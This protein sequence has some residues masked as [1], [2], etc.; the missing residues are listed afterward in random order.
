M[1]AGQAGLAD[2]GVARGADHACGGADAA[3]FAEMAAD[4]HDPVV[5]ELGTEADGAFVGTLCFADDEKSRRVLH[6]VL[7]S[8]STRVTAES[9]DRKEAQSSRLGA[10]RIGVYQPWMPSMDEGWTRLVLEKF[11][12]P[13]VTLHNAEICAGYLRGRVDTLLLPS[14]DAKEIRSGSSANETE[15]ADV[16]GSGRKGRRRCGPSSGRAG[17]WSAWKTRASTRTR[18]WACPSRMS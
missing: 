10:R 1:I 4:R 5:G 17:R 15:P 11:R 2:D 7:P 13:Y 14:I 12:F 9:G 8:V 6:R 16:G 18:S 3:S